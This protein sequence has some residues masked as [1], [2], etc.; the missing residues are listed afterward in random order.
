MEQQLHN[1]FGKR[2]NQA[3]KMKAWSL[4]VLRENIGEM[5]SIAAL[6]QYEK[7]KSMASSRVLVA[8]SEALEVSLDYF[9][10]DYEVELERIQFRK[11]SKL[12]K[13]E[14]DKV[15]EKARDFFE[16]YNQVEELL[17]ANINYESPI[18]E[19][20]G[21]DYEAMAKEVRKN[22]EIG[23]DPISNVHA[24]LE[25][26]GIKVWYAKECAEGFDGF[27]ANTSRGPVV[28]VAHK[29]TTPARRR[30]T[31]VHELAHILCDP[32]GMEEKEEEKFVPAFTGAL[33][34]PAEVL[35]KT[36]GVKRK[37][38]P[39]GE[40]LSIKKRFGVSMAGVLARAKSLGIIT[41]EAYTNYYRFGYAKNWRSQKEEAWDQELEQFFPE[42]H[43]RFNQLIFRAYGEEQLTISQVASYLETSVEEAEQLINSPE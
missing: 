42:R 22:W 21:L 29:H 27:S 39:L 17:G 11:K 14:Q 30:M 37:H 35:K 41:Q 24:L 26:K 34:L 43:F 4:A 13:K 33:L 36:L 20:L 15:T 6:S 19:S 38:V 18:K 3:R 7:G 25:E 10:R 16:R 31:A 9:F 2:L 23:Q 40:L 28:V 32:L 12:P 1:T 8:L 5:V